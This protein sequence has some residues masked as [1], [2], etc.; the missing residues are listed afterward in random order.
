MISPHSING[1]LARS[2]NR[3]GLIYV[4]LMLTFG[5]ITVF[6]LTD[7]AEKFR[8][9]NA[10]AEMFSRLDGNLKPGRNASKGSRPAGSPFL[11]GQ[12]VTVA[13][14]TL[15]QRITNII[16]AGGGTIVS[17]ELVQ[18][19]TQAKDGYITAIANCEL[20]EEALQ[21]VLYE[22]EAG[23]PF[24]FIDQ[25]NIQAPL[26]SGQGGRLRVRLGIAGLWPKGK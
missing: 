26:D 23:L 3:A 19:G 25:L 1:Y 16:T 13:S 4:G 14:A 2:H 18:Q 11:D 7:L 6:M 24:L 9:R 22:V 12:T 10:A 17:S 8:S 5:L 15:L 21:K 20:E